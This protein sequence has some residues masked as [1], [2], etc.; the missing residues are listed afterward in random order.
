MTSGKIENKRKDFVLLR[1]EASF[2][3]SIPGG[4]KRLIR[5]GAHADD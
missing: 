4:D 3:S 2:G 1:I 5:R